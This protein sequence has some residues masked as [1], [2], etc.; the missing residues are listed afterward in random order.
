MKGFQVG[1]S[2]RRSKKTKRVLPPGMINGSHGF[3]TENSAR[4]RREDETDAEK[5]AAS[6]MSDRNAAI[7]RGQGGI[8]TVRRID[9]WSSLHP[10]CMRV[11]DTPLTRK[12]A[13]VVIDGFLFNL[14][15]HC[16]RC[17]PVHRPVQSY[18][19]ALCRDTEKSL[20]PPGAQKYVNNSERPEALRAAV[21]IARKTTAAIRARTKVALEAYYVEHPELRPLPADVLRRRAHIPSSRS[22]KAVRGEGGLV[23]AVGGVHMEGGKKSGA[24]NEAYGCNLFTATLLSDTPWSHPTIEVGFGDH[25]YGLYARQYIPAF[26]IIALFGRSVDGYNS[27]NLDGGLKAVITHPKRSDVGGGSGGEAAA[28]AAA[29]GGGPAAADAM[30]R[31]VINLEDYSLDVSHRDGIK[32]CIPIARNG[33]QLHFG[34]FILFSQPLTFRARILL[35]I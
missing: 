10:E 35:T 32:T 33:T 16:G 2:V 5:L 23:I 21:E 29:A 26:T 27:L 14:R 4:R 25:G 9:P 12:M 7:Q 20:F 31:R 22:A 13:L 6:D 28:A 11:A 3:E 18:G 24:L 15:N 17:S 8:P 34:E 19:C 30:E 1:H